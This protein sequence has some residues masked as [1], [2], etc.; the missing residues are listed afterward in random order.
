MT[1]LPQRLPSR[2]LSAAVCSTMRFV[3]T[4]RPV[5]DNALDSALGCICGFAGDCS[6]CTPRKASAHRD[7]TSKRALSSTPPVATHTQLNELAR[8][9]YRALRPAP[10]P[11]LPQSTIS[12][13][14]SSPVLHKFSHHHPENMFNP[15]PRPG[16]GH[17]F[18]HE[19]A[20]P[21]PQSSGVASD[22]NRSLQS[23]PHQWGTMAGS[24]YLGLPLSNCGCGEACQCPG[25][26]HHRG[27][28]VLPLPSAFLSCSN[29][30]TCIS[31]LDCTILSLPPPTDGVMSYEQDALN[32]LIRQIEQANPSLDGNRWTGFQLS[33]DA[34]DA[35][36]VNPRGINASNDDQNTA[37]SSHF[38]DP[39]DWS[40][41]QTLQ[42][43]YSPL[44][45]LPPIAF[46][47]LDT[48]ST[49]SLTSLDIYD[50]LFDITRSSTKP[51]PSAGGILDLDQDTSAPSTGSG[52]TGI[53]LSRY[54]TITQHHFQS[55]PN[56]AI[57]S[58][59]QNSCCSSGST[60]SNTPSPHPQSD[61][62]VDYDDLD[63]TRP[64]DSSLT[65]MR[66][67]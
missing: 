34:L 25:C 47:N 11:A 57:R 58:D 17:D 42:S 20:A 41:P 6:C 10:A 13:N 9:R 45:S 27:F 26:A 5:A 14:P 44:G 61:S 19:Y 59:M 56:L 50:P 54:S 37:A 33:N 21:Q 22:F 23:N 49:N 4:F 48:Q 46:E 28:H 40:D 32:E 24:P 64:Y 66:I 53:P 62:G 52:R 43:T 65:D 39:S 55:T 51:D 3:H 36:D 38:A 30:S 63:R 8:A 31:C 18:S 2:T 12:H 15:Y 16:Y 1:T 29:P 7:S 35:R 60:P 67:F